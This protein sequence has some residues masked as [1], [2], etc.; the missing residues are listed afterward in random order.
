MFSF[1]IR[2]ASL[3]VGMFVSWVIWA[4]TSAFAI[5]LIWRQRFNMPT[6]SDPVFCLGPPQTTATSF[7]FSEKRRSQHDV[8]H[9]SNIHR[10]CVCVENMC[11]SQY[12]SIVHEKSF[13]PPIRAILITVIMFSGLVHKVGAIISP[14]S[15]IHSGCQ[16]LN[17]RNDFTHPFLIS[18]ADWVQQYHPSIHHAKG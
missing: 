13:L 2:V 1:R 10:V 8:R 14:V 4:S 3:L 9:K 7:T 12:L 11:I 5:R 17:G 16:R 6:S 15:P 18:K